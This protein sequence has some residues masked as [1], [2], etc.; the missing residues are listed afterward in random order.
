MVNGIDVTE[1]DPASDAHIA[2]TYD[3][4]RP[5]GK[6]ENKAALQREL[7]LSQDASAPLVGMVTR[8]SGQKGLDL[9][10]SV[11]G[12][13]METGIQLAVLGKGDSKYVDLFSWAESRWPGRVSA[14]FEMNGPLA[15]RIYAGADLFL[16]PSL[17]EPCGLSQMIAMRYGTVP[18]VRETGGLRDTVL[19]YNQHTGEGNGFTFFNYNAHDM[20]HT[21]E[22]AV[23]YYR[24]KPEVWKALMRRGMTEDFSWD[25]SAGQ[26]AD[27]YASLIAPDGAGASAPDQAE[28]PLV[29]VP[30]GR[31]KPVSGNAQQEPKE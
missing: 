17:F 16:M 1:Y 13:M 27:L 9:V 10:D 29:S 12:P 3:A 5:E 26:Y 21:L 28:A 2:A 20:L 19:S 24:D 30:E 15:H 6:A 14:R 7:G 25:H 18:L 31:A 23:E 8:L 11:I 22:R 4:D